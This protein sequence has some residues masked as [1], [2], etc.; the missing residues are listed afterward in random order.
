MSNEER[1][2]AHAASGVI[3]NNDNNNT[4]HKKWPFMKIHK[5]TK[6][7]LCAQRAVDEPIHL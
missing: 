3:N 4:R 6:M 5:F 1:A 2:R 7:N